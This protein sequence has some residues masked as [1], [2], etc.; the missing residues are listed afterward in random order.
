MSSRDFG[1]GNVVGLREQ[2]LLAISGEEMLLVYEN[3]VFSR[4]RG[5]MWSGTA[6]GHT[7]T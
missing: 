1:G 7:L 2:C 6:E 4:F 3:S 5:E